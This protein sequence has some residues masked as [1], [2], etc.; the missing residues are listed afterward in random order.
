[1]VSRLLTA[2]CGDSLNQILDLYQ[3][4]SRHPR[5]NSHLRSMFAY[6]AR[7]TLPSKATDLA[8]MVLSSD[9][10]V[11]STSIQVLQECHARI[12]M[13]D[14]PPAVGH[15]PA[16]Q[17]DDTSA[18][19]VETV[20]PTHHRGS[21]QYTSCR[22]DQRAA[23]V[24]RDVHKSHYTTL[25]EHSAEYI[26]IAPHAHRDTPRQVLRGLSWTYRARSGQI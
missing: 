12:R 14:A 17:I 1:M 7:Q 10:D 13:R 24:T 3:Y 25:R 26:S 15:M 5:H 21:L 11:Q 19:S 9:V 22:T 23:G 6:R 4:L 2:R 16:Q 18:R 8:N 20:A